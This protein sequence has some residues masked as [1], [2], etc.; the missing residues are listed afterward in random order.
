MWTRLSGRLG[1]LTVGPEPPETDGACHAGG[2]PY[3]TWSDGADLVALVFER[4]E[5]DAAFAA[6]AD[7]LDPTAAGLVAFAGNGPSWRDVL[8]AVGRGMEGN[9][10]RRASRRP[11]PLTRPTPRLAGFGSI[12]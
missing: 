8:P 6:L 10:R 12:R 2:Q 3:G 1:R 11:T 7:P 4:P 5:V 9:H